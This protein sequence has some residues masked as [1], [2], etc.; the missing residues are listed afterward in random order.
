MFKNIA[1]HT[2]HAK[3][4]NCYVLFSAADNSYNSLRYD[5]YRKNGIQ[6]IVLLQNGLRTG[7][8]ANDSVDL[9]T[10]CDYIQYC[11]SVKYLT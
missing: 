5:I 6:N 3:Q 4:I 11:M 1:T 9:Y 7:E 2:T 8:W 10:Y